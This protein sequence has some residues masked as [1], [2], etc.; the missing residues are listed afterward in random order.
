MSS[1]RS[2]GQISKA[3][4]VTVGGD[5]ARGLYGGPTYFHCDGSATTSDSY[6]LARLLVTSS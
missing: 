5:F 2:R 6:R 3:G 4:N 1:H